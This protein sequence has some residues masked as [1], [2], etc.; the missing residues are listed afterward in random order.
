VVTALTA[1]QPRCSA[2]ARCGRRTALPRSM[3]AARYGA[4][5]RSPETTNQESSAVRPGSPIPTDRPTRRP[6]PRSSNA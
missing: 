5:A 1:L 2:A 6:D 4:V 3:S